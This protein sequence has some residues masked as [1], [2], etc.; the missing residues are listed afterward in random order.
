MSIQIGFALIPEQKIIKNIVEAENDLQEKF[1][2]TST[3]G[4]AQNIPHITIFQNTFDDKIPYNT[5]LAKFAVEFTRL[6]IDK[7]RFEEIA[8]EYGG[9]YVQLLQ[10]TDK[11]QEL[12][13]YALYHTKDYI[14]GKP[15]SADENLPY[16]QQ[17][18]LLEWGYRYAGEAYMPHITLARATEN[19][20]NDEIITAFEERLAKTPKETRI[21]KL[22][23]YRMGENGTHAETL[24][25]VILLPC[26][27]STYVSY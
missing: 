6:Q 5:L 1:A 11:L 27:E 9:W 25:E 19:K 26:N 20:R 16:W 15:D 7:M 24:G 13:E 22:T 14:A 2:F 3:L 18:G 12:H 10:R 21:Q 8:Y 4:I 23:A 17:K